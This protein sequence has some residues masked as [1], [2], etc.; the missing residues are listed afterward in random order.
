MV[1]LTR[2][3]P[4]PPPAA[5]PDGAR[6]DM[7]DIGADSDSIERELEVLTTR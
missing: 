3:T 7:P 4:L 5:S 6:A 2:A 1:T